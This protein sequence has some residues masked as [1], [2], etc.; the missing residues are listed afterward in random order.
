LDVTAENNSQVQ[1]PLGATCQITPALINTGSATW[2]P[3]A[4]AFGG[5]VFHTSLSDF[6]LQNR[7]SYLQRTDWPSLQAAVTQNRVD[8]SGRLN[9]QGVG[10]FGEVLR[11][12]LLTK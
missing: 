3:A 5:V 12:T 9:I 7:V 1:V 8:I 4:Q 2:L 10:D 11:L 6:P